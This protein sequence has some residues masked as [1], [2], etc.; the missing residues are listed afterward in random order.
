MEQPVSKATEPPGPLDPSL[1][2]SSVWGPSPF[3]SGSGPCLA[4][5]PCF[6]C[7]HLG[8]APPKCTHHGAGEKSEGSSAPLPVRGPTVSPGTQT[9][10]SWGEL[11]PVLA[12]GEAQLVIGMS[13]PL[14][15]QPGVGGREEEKE[16]E[17]EKRGKEGR[18][19]WREASGSV[20]GWTGSWSVAPFSTRAPNSSPEREGVGHEEDEPRKAESPERERRQI[21]GDKHPHPTHTDSATHTHPHKGTLFPGLLPPPNLRDPRQRAPCPAIHTPAFTCLF[22]S[23]YALPPAHAHAPTHPAPHPALPPCCEGARFLL[24][25]NDTLGLT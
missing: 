5:G 3:P 21:Q 15:R 24:F 19:S 18:G 2:P 25:G 6:S 16:R 8:G 1:A 9:P 13:H 12:A 20:R 14:A 11:R 17:G 22:P 10:G 7:P 4:Q 23:T